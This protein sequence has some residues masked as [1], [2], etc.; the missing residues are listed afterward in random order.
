MPATRRKNML[1]RLALPVLAPRP[2]RRLRLEIQG[3][4]P[5][6]L[7]EYE[8]LLRKHHVLGSAALLSDG[9]R[10]TVLLCSTEKPL[11]RVST[12]SMFRIA[13][14]TKMAA[15]LAALVAAEQHRLLLD[16]PVLSCFPELGDLQ[17]LQGVTP[18]HL[19]SHTSGLRDPE[20]LESALVRGI[21]FPE[22]LN[23]AG[24]SEP[25]KVFQYSNLGFGLIGSLLER[26]YDEPVSLIMKK[27]VFDP[28]QM[29]ATVNASELREETIVP[30]TRVLPYRPGKD[31]IK[32]PLGERPLREPDPLRHYGY[33][34]GAMYLDLFSLEKLMIC[35]M[36]SGKPLL[37]SD[38]GKEMIRRHADY[39]KASPTL[40][41]GLGLLR[42]QDPTL[43]SSLLLGH[44]GFAY[45]CADGAFWEESTGKMV[46]FL[47]GGASEARRGRLGLCNYDVLKWALRKEMPEWSR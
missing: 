24:P 5:V 2:G 7:K 37:S 33:T 4:P 46:L 19:L 42:I 39:G 21:P 41:Y 17:A 9:K 18:R 14:I 35:L 6:H 8:K 3:D 1:Y 26:I 15:A 44:Q 47:N 43:S 22:I 30:I 38:L 40:S 34:A 45:G 16:Q 28:L 32:T 36:H 12:S 23:Q 25:G 27:L 13:S 11:H 31:L 29:N 10:R 20:G